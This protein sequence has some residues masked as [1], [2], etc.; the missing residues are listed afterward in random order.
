MV[1]PRI[2]ATLGCG[3]SLLLRLRAA[4]SLSPSLLCRTSP[5]CSS[6]C[7]G[8]VN[9]GMQLRAATSSGAVSLPGPAAPVPVAA[10]STCL[11]ASVPAPGGGSPAGVASTTGSPGRRE[12]S[13]ESS[14][15]ERRY[16][17]TSS[18]ERSQS[19]KKRPEGR[20]PSPAR[21][22]RLAHSSA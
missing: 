21:S 19:G 22:S 16:R 11:S 15:S 8:P 7:H 10:P 6:A 5:G 12:C 2:A 4:P 14:R 9:S 3:W 17:R 13:R 1:P 18:R 20:S